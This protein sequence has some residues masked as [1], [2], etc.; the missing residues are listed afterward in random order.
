MIV[1]IWRHGEAGNAVID[2]VRE[3]TDRGR[4]D[5]GFGCQQ[6][7]QHCAELGLAHPE[8]LLYS[9]WE[10]TLQTADIVGSAYNHARREP[11]NALIP[12]RSPG[13]VDTELNN[14]L[15]RQ[16][17]LAHVVL[18]SHQPLV[19]RLVDHYLGSPASVAPLVPGGLVTIELDV[20]AHDCGRLLF[21]AQP[22]TYTRQ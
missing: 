20:S 1:T 12:G 21:S 22:P 13:D 7:N 17:D 11:C 5:I 14:L 9:K 10:R 6:F 19:S 8:L 2:R 3:L 15:E 16:A 18:I 4:E